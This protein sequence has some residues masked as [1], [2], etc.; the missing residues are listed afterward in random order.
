MKSALWFVI[1]V[2]LM[3]TM[4]GLGSQLVGLSPP[5]PDVGSDERLGHVW[6]ALAAL[7]IVVTVDVAVIWLTLRRPPEGKLLTGDRF[8]KQ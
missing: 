4:V 2:T 5:T 3:L 1:A 7:A 8:R 6:L